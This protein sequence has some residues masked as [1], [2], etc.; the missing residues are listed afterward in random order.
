[1]GLEMGPGTMNKYAVVTT[2]VF[3]LAIAGLGISLSSGPTTD[4][5]LRRVDCEAIT[6][7]TP[8]HSK[9]AEELCANYGGVAHKDSE[10]S[11]NG[12]VILVRNQPVGGFAGE[13]AVR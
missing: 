13:N 8:A 4:R 5:E 7:F 1:M 12:L 9:S 3:A 6:M 2:S 10:P 11:K